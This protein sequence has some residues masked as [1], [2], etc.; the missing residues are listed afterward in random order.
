MYVFDISLAL[1]FE[2]GLFSAFQSDQTEPRVWRCCD[3]VWRF[4]TSWVAAHGSRKESFLQHKSMI[5]FMPYFNFCMF[6]HCTI[7]PNIG[8]LFIGAC[9]N[10]EFAAMT[11]CTWTAVRMCKL[12]GDTL[13]WLGYEILNYAASIKCLCFI[14]TYS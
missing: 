10:F 11:R 4:V 1:V 6:D 14:M 2:V 9:R 5:F 8:E 7:L 3:V 13:F 12:N